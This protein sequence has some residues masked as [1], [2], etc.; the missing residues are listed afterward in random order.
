M[1]D[2]EVTISFWLSL[3]CVFVFD[4]EVNKLFGPSLYCVF[5]FDFEVNKSMKKSPGLTWTAHNGVGPHRLLPED[6]KV[7]YK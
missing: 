5:V 4:F 7:K 1:F 6:G 2:F 3:Y